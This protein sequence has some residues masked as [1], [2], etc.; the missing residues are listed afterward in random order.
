MKT[1]F[2]RNAAA[3]ASVVG[4]AGA[5]MALAAPAAQAAPR[6]VTTQSSWYVEFADGAPGVGEL[7]VGDT[8]DAVDAALDQAT[9]IDRQWVFLEDMPGPAS[10]LG[11]HLGVDADDEG[12]QVQV[13]C[14]NY[15][16]WQDYLD[17]LCTGWMGK[18][19]AR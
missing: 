11:V 13:M 17:R 12:D 7:T 4:L 8:V 10:A 16:T 5:G 2:A 19:P 6:V 9:G 18:P 15:N 3:V 1:R 14:S